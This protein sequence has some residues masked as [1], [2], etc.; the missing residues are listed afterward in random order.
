MGTF[1]KEAFPPDDP[2]LAEFVEWVTVIDRDAWLCY[3]C[4]KGLGEHLGRFIGSSP[5]DDVPHAT[6]RM[7]VLIYRFLRAESARHWEFKHALDRYIRDHNLIRQHF[8]YH[9]A[10]EF[11]GPRTSPYELMSP[12]T[13]ELPAAVEKFRLANRIESE[14]E[15][16]R[17]LIDL[18]LEIAKHRN[19]E[20]KC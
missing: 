10:E 19:P 11:Y 4:E 13:P 5:F 1:E 3:L 12:R 20:Q 7:T 18:G 8:K 2:Q 17:V 6:R 14:A 15:A 9:T 16:V